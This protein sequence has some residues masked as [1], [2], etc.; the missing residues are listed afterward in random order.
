MTIIEALAQLH[1]IRISMAVLVDDPGSYEEKDWEADVAGWFKG[2]EEALD[3]I[4]ESIG[5]DTDE[6]QE[7]IEEGLE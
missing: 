6:L 5:T 2:I 4:I 1:D 3:S 7:I